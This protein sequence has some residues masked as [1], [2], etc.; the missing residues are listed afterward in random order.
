MSHSAKNTRQGWIAV[1]NTD[2]P[3][4]EKELSDDDLEN[5]VIAS[6]VSGRES[7]L[8]KNAEEQ[9]VLDWN[10]PAD[11]VLGDQAFCIDFSPT[12]DMIIAGAINGSLMMYGSI[13][14][15]ISRV[16]LCCLLVG[17]IMALSKT[18]LPLKSMACTGKLVAASS[19]LQMVLV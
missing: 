10:A 11:I 12:Q 3:T 7:F 8:Q 14:R 18:R 17:L 6:G 19:S 2:L 16:R 9:K 13:E 15:S 5:F 4:M 1:R